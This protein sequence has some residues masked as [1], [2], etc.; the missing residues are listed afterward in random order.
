MSE[1]LDWTATPAAPVVVVTDGSAFDCAAAAL[2]EKCGYR[3]DLVPL[4]GVADQRPRV[5]IVRDELMAARVARDL[6]G[7]PVPLVVLIPSG[8]SSRRVGRTH[9]LRG[10]SA[11]S[12]LGR[13]LHNAVGPAAGTRRDLVHLSH[14]ER[15]VVTEY[16]LGATI[17]ETAQRFTLAE[18][19]VKSH[20]RR[21]AAK[22]EAA[23]R[24]AQ[25]KA[26]LLLQMVADGWITLPGAE[27]GPVRTSGA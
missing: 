1:A 21:V 14:R 24:P 27:T 13:I 17:T 10:S 9:L 15:E 19:T 3:A 26:Q 11:A 16:V 23:G 7:R 4:N 6:P 25:N 22:Y 8:Q 20:K 18:A 12:E 2:V 5:V